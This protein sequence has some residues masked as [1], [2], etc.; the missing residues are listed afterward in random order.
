MYR[1]VYKSVCECVWFSLFLF[2]FYYN[3]TFEMPMDVSIYGTPDW[4]HPGVNFFLFSAGRSVVSYVTFTLFELCMSMLSG[5][6]FVVF[7]SLTLSERTENGPLKLTQTIAKTFRPPTWPHGIKD[8][9]ALQCL[10]VVLV[11]FIFYQCNWTWNIIRFK[12]FI[13]VFRSSV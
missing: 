5:Y 9:F 11:Y 2:A 3:L 1:W 10:F 7:V 8:L 12:F 6:L 13:F 4:L